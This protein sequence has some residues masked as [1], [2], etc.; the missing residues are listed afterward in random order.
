[1]A[2]GIERGSVRGEPLGSLLRRNW[3]ALAIAVMAVV[4]IGIG[5]YLTTEH[6]AKVEPICPTVGPINC[7]S[8]L[9]S[10]YSVVPLTGSPT[11]GIPIT[12][13]G[14]VFFLVSGGL[15]VWM[16]VRA[17]RGEEEP[18]WMRPALALWSLAGLLFVLYLVFAEIVLIRSICLWCTGVHILTLVTLLLA[19]S[20]WQQGSLEHYA[21]GARANAPQEGS[22]QATRPRAAR[23][24]QVPSRRAQAQVRRATS[25]TV[26]ARSGRH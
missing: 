15:A 3:Q 7:S 12:V 13:P 16:L 19:L 2:V 6:Y 8:V 10:Q 25:G 5:I 17:Y 21:S 11:S 4:G 1:M 24:T 26:K 23:V 22:R 9:R 18:S 20:L 14:A